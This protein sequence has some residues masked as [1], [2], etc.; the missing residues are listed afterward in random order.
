MFQVKNILLLSSLK[1][2]PL[3]TVRGYKPGSA[4]MAGRQAKMLNKLLVNAK[5]KR[6]REWFDVNAA[7]KPTSIA[8]THQENKIASRRVAVLNKLFMKHV[9]DLLATS[10]IGEEIA[11]LAIEITRVKVCQNF[12]GLNVF[13]YSTASDSQLLMI[14]ER[15]AKIAGPL[16]H[17]MS[18]LRLM[19]EVPRITFVKDRQHSLLNEVDILLAT[20][21]FGD[22]Y[23]RNPYGQ[24]VKKDF[25]STTAAIDANDSTSDVMP[26]RNDLFG[27]DRNAIMGRIERSLAKTQHA[28]E[29]FQSGTMSSRSGSAQRGTSFDSLQQTSAREKKCDEILQNFL[30]ARK[31]ERK[32]KHKNGMDERQ[33]L[34]L[35]PSDYRE[36][37]DNDDESDCDDD[38][39]YFD[40]LDPSD[41]K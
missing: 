12:H 14:E 1:R 38:N 29:A 9:T 36:E 34:E 27:V 31:L 19:G 26:M 30:A 8:S 32:L 23:E 22:N 28:W 5:K 7:S 37:W 35:E 4:P 25:D 18:Q 10:R 11:G 13:W 3:V 41:P 16:R 17:E 40:T 6:S 2:L 15:L 21:D 20:A 39:H 24:R 33:L